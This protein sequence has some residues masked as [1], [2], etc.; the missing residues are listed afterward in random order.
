MCFFVFRFLIPVRVSTCVDDHQYFIICLIGR[1]HLCS[2]H[3]LRV[4][5]Y[6]SNRPCVFLHMTSF[7]LQSD[8]CLPYV[9]PT[10]VKRSY[11]DVSQLVLLLEDETSKRPVDHRTWSSIIGKVVLVQHRQNAKRPPAACRPTA[12]PRVCSMVLP[13]AGHPIMHP[14]G[15]VP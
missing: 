4:T 1:L 6:S 12:R 8:G 14:L 5:S 13:H 11:T 2:E 15:H 7:F 9:I 10:F 3:G